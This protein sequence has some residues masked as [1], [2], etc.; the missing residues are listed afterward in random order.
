MIEAWDISNAVLGMI[1]TMAVQRAFFRVSYECR[2]HYRRSMLT[3]HNQIFIALFLSR[4]YKHDQT[5][6]A[7]WSGKWVSVVTWQVENMR[8][9]QV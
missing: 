1:A 4:E 6:R 2:L 5:N 3:L 8:I 9:G 7:W